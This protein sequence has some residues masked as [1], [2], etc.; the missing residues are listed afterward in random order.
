MMCFVR[1]GSAETRGLVVQGAT[2]DHQG[3]II[4][5]SDVLAPGVSIVI[6]VTFVKREVK[7]RS[8][9]GPGTAGTC[10]PYRVA[11]TPA[12]LHPFRCADL[13]SSRG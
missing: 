3:G 4:S 8:G 2:N 12:T 13:N 1:Y 11:P 7:A 6:Q 9:L 10:H 5:L